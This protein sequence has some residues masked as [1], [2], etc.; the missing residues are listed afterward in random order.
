MSA[1][2]TDWG[3]KPVSPDRGAQQDTTPT[4]VETS[5]ALKT[6]L[7]TIV[8]IIHLIFSGCLFNF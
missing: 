4:K 6:D 1:A 5:S 2:R 7:Y 3:R 8:W